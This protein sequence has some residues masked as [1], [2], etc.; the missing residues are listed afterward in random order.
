MKHPL[1]PALNL[2]QERSVRLYFAVELFPE[3]TFQVSKT[4][5]VSEPDSL[6]PP[7]R[8]SAIFPLNTTEQKPLGGCF[9]S[10]F[11][12]SA[13]KGSFSMTALMG[14]S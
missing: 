5:K 3:K 9:T 2:F 11:L 13:R 6:V 7:N 4:W 12:A 14:F 8:A 1:Q 10:P